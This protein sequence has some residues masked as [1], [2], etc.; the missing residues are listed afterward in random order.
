[1]QL[2]DPAGGGMAQGQRV[3]GPLHQA[4]VLGFEKRDGAPDIAEHEQVDVGHRTLG[5]RVVEDLGHRGALQRQRAQTPRLEAAQEAPAEVELVDAAGEKSA[6]GPAPL[7]T[8]RVGHRAHDVGGGGGEAHETLAGRFGQERP[9]LRG[10]PGSGGD[11]AHK[12]VA[13]GRACWL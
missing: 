7:G 4:K 8:N 11:A 12:P 6:G 9:G 10:V 13:P 3:I 1:M 2:D 5:R